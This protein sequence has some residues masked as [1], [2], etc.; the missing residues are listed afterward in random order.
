MSVKKS[1][2]KTKRLWEEDLE[3]EI[4]AVGEGEGTHTVVGPVK[5]SKIVECHHRGRCQRYHFRAEMS[6][7]S[8]VTEKASFLDRWSVSRVQSLG[9]SIPSPSSI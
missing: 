8:I 4:W 7:T 2:I 9:L 1:V 3:G 6:R 5:G